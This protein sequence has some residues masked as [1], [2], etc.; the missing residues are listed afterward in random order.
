ML[1]HRPLCEGNNTGGFVLL[2]LG[3]HGAFEVF[4]LVVVPVVGLVWFFS[5]SFFFFFFFFGGGLGGEDVRAIPC[6]SAGGGQA[7][8][9]ERALILKASEE[10]KENRSELLRWGEE[11]RRR[12]FGRDEVCDWGSGSAT[13]RWPH[14]KESAS[15]HVAVGVP[16][17][18]LPTPLSRPA[19]RSPGHAWAP[20]EPRPFADGQVA[21]PTALARRETP[22]P[23]P[24]RPSSGSLRALGGR[25]PP[26]VLP[27]SLPP[28]FCRERCRHVR[29]PPV[30]DRAG[31][32]ELLTCLKKYICVSRNGSTDG[33]RSHRGDFSRWHTPSGADEW[34]VFMAGR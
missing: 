26:A 10:Q 2:Q 7:G 1:Q 24:T 17:C 23:E 14:W 30:P 13:E 25:L 18:G 15:T 20:R 5:F 29:H 19:R 16:R 9:P 27:P 22:A 28:V 6:G 8:F 34:F 4:L 21:G 31:R 33:A 32:E 3:T 12:Y 11:G